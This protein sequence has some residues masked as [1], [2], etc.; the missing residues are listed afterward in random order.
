MNDIVTCPYNIAHAVKRGR[1]QIHLMKCQKTSKNAPLMKICN[2]NSSH[3]ILREKMDAHIEICPERIRYDQRRHLALHLANS[4]YDNPIYH[5]YKQI[6]AKEPE[7]EGDWE[8]DEEKDNIE[9]GDEL[10]NMEDNKVDFLEAWIKEVE[11]EA[12]KA[13]NLD[14][15]HLVQDGKLKA[16]HKSMKDVKDAECCDDMTASTM[17]GHN[18]VTA[19]TMRDHDDFTASSMKGHGGVTASTMRGHDDVTASTMSCHDDIT[20]SSMKG[21]DDATASTMGGHDDFIIAS[22]SRGREGIKVLKRRPVLRKETG[23]NRYDT[24]DDDLPLHSKRDA[25]L[26]K[27]RGDDDLMTDGD[28][29][30]SSVASH[31]MAGSHIHNIFRRMSIRK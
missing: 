23:S 6:T 10:T 8:S 27:V 28:D 26:T 5:V 29:E 18:Y 7:I 31:G 3:R 14:N 25:V 4:N 20:A 30:A 17:S 15:G 1:L 21:H 11:L 2:F 9:L 19:S 12:Q 22:K 16:D 13:R 24:S